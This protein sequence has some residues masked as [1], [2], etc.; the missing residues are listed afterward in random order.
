MK[1]V[2]NACLLVVA[3]AGCNGSTGGGLTTFAAYVGGPAGVVAGQP[4]TF[5]ST[6]GYDISLTEAR[7]H[8]AA[9]YFNQLVPSSGSP[10]QAC[11]LPG[12]YVDEVF[13]ACASTNSCGVDADLLSGALVPFP[14]PGDGTLN[15]A[16]TAAVWLS[17]G[18][19]NAADDETPLLQVAG[20]AEKDGLSWPFTGLVTI[21]SNHA[22]APS[23]VATPGQH[24]I[25]LQ[26]IVAPPLVAE[27]V[28]TGVTIDNGGTLTMRVNLANIFNSVDFETWAP[29]GATTTL[30]IPNDSSVFGLQLFSGFTSNAGPPPPGKPDLRVYQFDVSNPQ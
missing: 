2:V 25:C 23:S 9:I 29:T 18:D 14:T 17:G 10:E 27:G 28:T 20:T 19:I 1:R 11:I 21:G 13:G 22:Q 3:M 12:V 4:F 7:F 16:F 24:P 26:R 15:Q 5:T 30:T 6:N 8:V